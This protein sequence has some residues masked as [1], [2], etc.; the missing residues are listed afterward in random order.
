MAVVFGLGAAVYGSGIIE[1][2]SLESIL[3]RL[4]DRLGG[5]TY[6]LVGV[7]AYLETAAFVGL[8]APGE[9]AVIF[10]GFV[11]GQGRINA[12]AL[13]FLVWFCAAAGDST[14]YLL[15]RRLG[16]GWALQAWPARSA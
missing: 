13:F 16:R 8:V 1:V 5:W 9:V 3:T 11:A 10:G 6:L 7:M 12:V 4:S 14:G 2:P 15:G